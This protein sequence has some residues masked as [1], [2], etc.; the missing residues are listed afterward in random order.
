MTDIRHKLAASCD[1]AAGNQLALRSGRPAEREYLLSFNSGFDVI[2]FSWC[3]SSFLVELC[4]NTTEF[5]KVSPCV[6][7]MLSYAQIQILWC[8]AICNMYKLYM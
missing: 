8:I 3:L 7:C 4:L 5:R 6:Q 2:L 1:T